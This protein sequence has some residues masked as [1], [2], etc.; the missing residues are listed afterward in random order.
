LP[1][2]PEFSLHPIRAKKI[3]SKD[4]NRVFGGR[5]SMGGNGRFWRILLKNSF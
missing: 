2:F 5:A 3:S 4:D 1:S